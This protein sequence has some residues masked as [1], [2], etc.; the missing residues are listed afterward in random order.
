M[1]PTE[2]YPLAAL[3]AIIVFLVWQTARG[4]EVGRHAWVLPA[5]LSAAFLVF[6]LYTIAQEG[7]WPV[8]ENHSQN[9][10]GNQVWF[11]LLIGLGI[12]WAVMLPRA[13]A[14]GM[15]PWPWLLAV[16]VTA[17]IAMLAMLAR[18]LFLDARARSKPA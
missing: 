12:S 4:R 2:A 1:H 7:I 18:V 8:I 3:A 9:L 14:L 5:L 10:W 13:R 15:L 17:N 11:D 6:S 16:I